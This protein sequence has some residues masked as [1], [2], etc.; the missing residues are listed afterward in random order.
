MFENGQVFFLNLNQKMNTFSS[1]SVGKKL[2]ACDIGTFLLMVDRRFEK[3]QVG[4]L[5]TDTA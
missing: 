2:G 5:G 3:I 1:N 4:I